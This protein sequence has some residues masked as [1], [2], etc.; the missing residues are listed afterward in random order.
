MCRPG[1]DHSLPADRTHCWYR[2]KLAARLDS[3]GPARHTQCYLLSLQRVIQQMMRNVLAPL[4][5]HMSNDLDLDTVQ[6]GALLSACA[7][8]TLFT[9]TPG[10]A[11]ADKMGAKKLVTYAMAASAL[12]CLAVP[13]C[14][15]YFGRSGL[16]WIIALMGAVQGPL[17]P[18]SNVIL[19]HW[20]P[21][22]SAEG[23]DEKAWGTSMLDIGISIGSLVSIPLSNF[24]AV[25]VGWQ[26]A[27]HIIGLSGLAFVLLWHLLGAESPTSCWFIQ[28]RELEY[29][30]SLDKQTIQDFPHNQ[31]KALLGV[32]IKFLY[33]PALWAIFFAHV[34]FNYGAYM[35]TNWNPTYYSE[36]LNMRP[37]EMSLH[38]SMPNVL[39]LMATLL[40]PTLNRKADAMG[41]KDLNSRRLFTAA[42]FMG[43]AAMMLPI[44]LLRSRDPWVTTFFFGFGNAFFGLARNGFKSNYLDVTNK[45]V[46]TVSGIGNTLGTA[47]LWFG[48]QFIAYVLINFAS[49]NAVFCSIAVMNTVASINF[50]WFAT[51]T[52]LEEEEERRR[53][54]RDSFSI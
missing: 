9:Q 46:G 51:A 19:S 11:L 13:T 14:S 43:S 40:N 21:K 33:H 48:P 5:L 25:T 27:Y 17:M 6:K 39:N 15:R 10:G 37:A 50:V 49:W 45:Y 53:K 30:G 35:I 3:L 52:P 23:T 32:P 8:G 47:A 38:L 44:Y 2:S 36:V 34:T 28:M 16:W 31:K 24:L 20:I 1:S 29:L 7:A 41:F 54:K 4:L 12:C 42:G 26:N 18:T 22:K